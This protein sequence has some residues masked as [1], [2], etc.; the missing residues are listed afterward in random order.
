MACV[1]KLLRHYLIQAEHCL[2]VREIKGGDS[3]ADGLATKL[4]RALL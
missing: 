2:Q 4:P 3:D 1:A